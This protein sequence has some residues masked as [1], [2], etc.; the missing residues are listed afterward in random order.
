[1]PVTAETAMKLG[2]VNEMA[3]AYGT[4]PEFHGRH[5]QRDVAVKY[6]EARQVLVLTYLD[7]EQELEMPLPPLADVVV[8]HG[9][10]RWPGGRVEPAEDDFGLAVALA[11]VINVR[12]NMSP[13]ERR[14]SE[15]MPFAQRWQYAVVN[16][17]A[18]K[19]AERMTE[20]LA[21]AGAGGWELISIYDKASNWIGGTEKG[22][23]LLKRPV[24][25]NV[26]PDEWCITYRNV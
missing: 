3:K 11:H 6:N 19:T 12:F 9:E 8:E 10:F 20:V 7:N 5:H 1:M 26:E 14:L 24:P 22:F 25:D 13:S 2:Y 17:G 18:F 21:T 23:M 16:T 15:P 4:F